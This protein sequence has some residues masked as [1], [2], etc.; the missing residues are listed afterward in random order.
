M[1]PEELNRL[2]LPHTSEIAKTTVALFKHVSGKSDH[3]AS[4]VL[5]Q[6]DATRFLVTAAHVS[7]EFFCE[8]WKQIFFG[9]PSEDDLIP[10]ITVNYARSKKRTDPNREDDRLDLAV[11]ELRPDIADKLSGFMR[12]ATLS[13]LELNPDKLKDGRYLVMGY[14]EFRTEKDV[15]EQRIIAEV[16][17]YFTG[18][19]DMQ[20]DPP[21]NIIPADHL[22]LG[23][24]CE[25]E[26]G[27]VWYGLN[28]DE[29]HGISGGGMWRILDEEQPVESLD[30]RQAK[31]VAIV[32]DRSDPGATG[33]VQYLRGTKIKRVVNFIYVGWPA[34]RPAIESAVPV[35]FVQ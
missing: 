3:Y 9:T 34:L 8:Q 4:G 30:W 17:P 25:H 5:L 12:F 23:V 29:T 2:V 32:T 16:L 13:D 28:L 14:P 1:N 7:D 33:P 21:P 18:L 35:R 27:S 24:N 6:V 22:V 15:I 11:L 19:Y 31:L 10:V 20:G 26:A